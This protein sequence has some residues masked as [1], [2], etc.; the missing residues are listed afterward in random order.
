MTTKRIPELPCEIHFRGGVAIGDLTPD[1][2]FVRA[3]GVYTLVWQDG[4]CGN[5]IAVFDTA[6]TPDPVSK[7]ADA[8]IDAADEAAGTSGDSV[9]LPEDEAALHASADWMSRAREAMEQLKGT[10]DN[11]LFAWYFVE[12][13]RKNTEYDPE[14]DGLVEYWL[15]SKLG[16]MIVDYE[17]SD[18]AITDRIN[19]SVDPSDDESLF[20]T[21]AARRALGQTDN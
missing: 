1:L 3:N 18:R 12:S 10:I 9:Y 21:S 11:P 4:G 17:A 15:Y 8:R 2:V 7:E 19:A 6:P 5:T 14:E 13:L 20:V 16:Q